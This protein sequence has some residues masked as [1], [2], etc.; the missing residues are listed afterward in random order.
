MRLVSVTRSA[1]LH[2]RMLEVEPMTPPHPM[3]PIVLDEV[4]VF[5]FKENA[6]VCA[7]LDTGTLDMNKIAMMTFS[8]E[9][10]EQFAQLIGYSVEG[11]S[12][13]SYVSD[14]LIERAQA[15]CD[16]LIK[17]EQTT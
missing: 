5:R 16:A 10:R 7:L 13:L 3:Q 11:A 12:E 14:A 15:E 17:G 4:G 1:A 9:D 8:R 6:I 2:L